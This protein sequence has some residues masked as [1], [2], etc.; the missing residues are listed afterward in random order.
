M[1]SAT[2]MAGLFGSVTAVV[3]SAAFLSA[4]LR[5][6]RQPT[7]RPL[8]A[9]A[10]VLVAGAVAHLL[11][12]EL[13]PFRA[14]F[15][16]AAN[17]ATS[18]GLWLLVAVDVAALASVAW[19]VFALQYTGRDD[20]ASSIAAVAVAVVVV[21][22]LVPHAVLTVSGSVVGFETATPNLVLGAAVV[23]AEALALV[24]VFLVVDATFQHKAFSA[25]QTLLQ[26]VAVGCILLLP[27]V[28]TTVRRPVATPLLIAVASALFA[29]LVSRYRLFETLP[30]VSVVGRDRVIEEMTDGVVVVG[31]DGR[32]R[33]LNPRAESLFDVD[34]ST[35]IGERLAAVAPAL[36]EVSTTGESPSDVRL[37]SGRTVSVS[38]ETIPD[39]RGRVLGR[40]LV[41]RDVTEQRRQAQRLGVLTRALSGVTSEQLRSVTDV[42]TAIAADELDPEDG[43]DRVREAAT[44]TATLVA[45]VREIERALSTLDP[46]AD[47][48]GRRSSTD[49]DALLDSLSVPEEADLLAET[50]D[51]PGQI[52][53][54]T[55]LARATLE[56][57]A[58]GPDEP[59]IRVADD[60]DAI[61]ISIAPFDPTG[62]DA[63]ESHALRIAERAAANTPWDLDVE[64]DS[65]PP[66]VR[67]RFQRPAG[68]TPSPGGDAG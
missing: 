20:R 58:A 48:P 36:A 37:D 31:D 39:R 8:L 57:L 49:L 7:A 11:L 64:A 17:S 18:G 24:G 56:T 9:V 14:A 33:D 4:V 2:S 32:L 42:T 59:T 10:A 28:A 16:L 3:A 61:T 66:R 6:R 50:A 55:T 23:L 34:R 5:S 62:T 40:L 19:F 46:A 35:A 29:G 45:S 26:V 43:G 52:V 68:E 25:S 13:A 22:L 47:G 67:L 27:F 44:E 15:G 63:L 38:T 21:P 1:S 41:C 12:V 54:D 53:A 65:T 60:A 30:V 51:Q